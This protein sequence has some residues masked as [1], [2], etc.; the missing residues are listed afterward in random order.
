MTPVLC[1]MR[2]LV[3]LATML[4]SAYCAGS[5]RAET[6]GSGTASNSV[7]AEDGPPRSL[8][9]VAPPA[10][11]GGIASYRQIIAREAAREGL[12]AA[13]AEAV[14]AVESGYNPAAVGS[15]GEI[16]LMQLMPSTA[17]MLGFAGTNS[18]LAQPETNIRL[19]VTYLAKAWRLA[20][21]DI[22][23][24]TMKYR[25]GHGET[26][27]S[28]LSVNYCLAVRAKLAAIG[29]AVTGVVPVATFGNGGIGGGVAAADHGCRRCLGGR[30]GTVNIAALNANLTAL[31]AQVRGGK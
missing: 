25:A 20:N 1:N 2:A 11:G 26:R 4:A 18:D 16:G 14:T 19:G 30:I 21:G 7:S 13:I 24:A 10:S 15:S 3:I 28:V 29:Y 31:V 6:D 22:C 17:R 8:G 9:P 23:T 12:P 5:A 27:F